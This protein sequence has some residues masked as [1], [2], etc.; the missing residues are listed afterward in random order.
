MSHRRASDQGFPDAAVCPCLNTRGRTVAHSL[1]ILGKQHQTRYSRHF[2]RENDA[3]F[4]KTKTR[5][6]WPTSVPR[7]APCVRQGAPTADNL[8]RRPRPPALFNCGLV[9]SQMPKIATIISFWGRTVQ[10]ATHG[11]HP[12]PIS[13]FWQG[14]EF[15][16]GRCVPCP[17]T[18]ARA[19]WRRC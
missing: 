3:T 8:H 10:P 16:L 1:R 15:T 12:L 7:P 9:L 5:A 2:P 19:S 17:S 11:R 14:P 18:G 4:P 13:S 6:F